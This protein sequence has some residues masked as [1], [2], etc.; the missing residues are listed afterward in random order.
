M[1]LPNCNRSE[2][3][4][5]P[6]I[7]DTNSTMLLAQKF[8]S[9]LIP[10]LAQLHDRGKRL[11]TKARKTFDGTFSEFRSWWKKIKEYLY[12]N[13]LSL[14]TDKIKIQTVGTFL[15]GNALTWYQMR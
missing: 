14:S 6:Y 2:P 13:T 10:H 15:K 9:D 4:D 3:E 7:T 1:V 5:N 11:P 12:I 8:L